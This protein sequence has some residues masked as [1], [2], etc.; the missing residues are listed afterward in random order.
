MRAILLAELRGQAVIV[1][2]NREPYIHVRHGD[3]ID[4]QRPA[5]GVVT[6]LEPIMRACSGTWIAHGSGSADR[7]V[8]DRDDRVAVPSERPAYQLRRVWLS[9]E[10][11]AGLLLRLC[12]RRALAAV[13]HRPRAPDIP[14]LGLGAVRQG[15]PQVRRRRRPRVGI[16]RSDRAG[17]GLPPGAVA[18]DDSGSAPGR[19]DH[20]LLAHSLAEPGSIRHLSLARGAARRPARQQHP[21]ISH[22]VSLQQLHRYGRSIARSAGRPG[23][24]QRVVPGQADSGEALSDLGRVAPV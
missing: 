1:V 10:E 24:V 12:E 16:S 23:N 18:A 15:Q 20:H 2:S 5:S 8:V 6:A 11:E 9:A 13:S 7:D 17:P 19:H 3:S 21:R 14:H 4:V 22:A